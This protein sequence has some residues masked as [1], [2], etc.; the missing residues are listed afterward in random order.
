MGIAKLVPREWEWEWEG[1]QPL[2]F[3]IS[4]PWIGDHQILLMDPCFG[5]VICQRLLGFTLDIHETLRALTLH[6][7]C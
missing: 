5:I 2:H 7:Y 3:P 6:V 4:S 1:V